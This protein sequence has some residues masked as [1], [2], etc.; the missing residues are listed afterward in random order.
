MPLTGLGAGLRH[1]DANE[2]GTV[3]EAKKRN[4]KVYDRMLNE[5][6]TLLQAS[7]TSSPSV[8]HT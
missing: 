7:T 8:G 5:T 2:M 3:V 1:L 6:R 4:T